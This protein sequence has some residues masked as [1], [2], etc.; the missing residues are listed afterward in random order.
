[1]PQEDIVE[2]NIKPGWKSGTKITFAERGDEYPGKIP[3]DM[4]FEIEELPHPIFKREGNDLVM[5]HTVSLKEALVG[6]HVNVTTL[7]GRHLKVN[8][9]DVIAPNYEKRVKGEGMPNSKDPNV[10]GD[11]VIRFRVRWPSSLSEQQ[12]AQLAS[13]L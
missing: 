6:T 3:A 2:I 13:V 1:M 5:N 10:K 9:R 11:L 4:V 7:S 12:K 8:V